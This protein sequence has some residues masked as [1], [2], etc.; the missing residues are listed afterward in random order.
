MIIY[1]IKINSPMERKS[2][3]KTT[4]L[5]KPSEN[6]L[7]YTIAQEQPKSLLP[8]QEFLCGSLT[9]KLLML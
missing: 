1:L 9:E 8:V 6:W 5:E 4:L 2:L 3:L 7:Y